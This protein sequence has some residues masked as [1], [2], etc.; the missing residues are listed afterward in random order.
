MIGIRW[1][2]VAQDSLIRCWTLANSERRK[3]ITATVAE[4]E[5]ELKAGASSLGESRSGGDRVVLRGVVAI[6]FCISEDDGF[7]RI[8]RMWLH[9]PNR[10]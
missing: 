8:L 4:L 10:R 7:V 9:E 3:A 5:K 2:K 6:E 1:A